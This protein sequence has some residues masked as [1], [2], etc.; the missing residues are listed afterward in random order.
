MAGKARVTT[1]NLKHAAS[2]DQHGKSKHGVVVTDDRIPED[3]DL[4]LIV[5]LRFGTRK[6]DG[7]GHPAATLH[8]TEEVQAVIRGVRSKHTARARFWEEYALK[9][10]TLLLVIQSA[11]PHSSVL[12]SSPFGHR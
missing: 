4:H 6:C 9:Q 5:P 2:R 1:E 10:N 3:A 8:T 11:S 7:S 12:F